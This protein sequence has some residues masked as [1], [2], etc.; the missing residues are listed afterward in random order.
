MTFLWGTLWG[1]PTLAARVGGLCVLLLLIPSATQAQLAEVL[2]ESNVENASVVVDGREVG[3]TDGEGLAFV[4]ALPPGRHTVELRKP[5]YWN[6]SV[7]V[8]LEPGLT[9]PVVLELRSRTGSSVGNLL[10]ETNVAGAVVVLDGEEIGETG[11]TGQMFVSGVEPGTHQ[12]VAR[13]EGYASVSR[14]VTIGET[15]LD[16]TTRLQ[17]AERTGGDPSRP[18]PTDEPEPTITAGVGM[19]DSVRSS[20]PAGG[21]I[22]TR[23]PALIVNAEME[24]ATV[25]VNDSIFGQTGPSGRLRVLVDSGQHEVAVSKEGL[26]PAQ[27][28]TTVQVGVGDERTLTLDLKQMGS[29]R[30]AGTEVMLVLSFLGLS[31][32]VALFVVGIS[33]PGGTFVRWVRERL[34]I[35]RRAR[36]ELARWVRHPFQDRQPFDQYY[37]VRELRTGEFATVYLAHD[38]EMR[39]QVRLRVLDRPYAGKPDHAKSFLDGGRLLKHLRGAVPDAPI[40]TAYRCGRENGAEDGRPFVALEYFQGKTLIAHMGEVGPLAVDDALDVVRQ[41]CVGLR[42]AHENDI[43]HGHLTPANIVIT[44]EDPQ[45]EIKLTGF[46]DLEYKHTTEILTDGYTEGITSYL[47]PDEIEGGKS[48]WQSDMYSVGVLFYKMVTGSP[49]FTHENPVRIVEMHQEAQPPPLPER[50]P[51]TIQPVFY[52][53]LSKDPDQRPTAKNVISVLDLVQATT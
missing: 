19:P 32:I 3:R 51:S 47:S 38:P 14:T 46:G 36:Y 10:V 27:A 28:Q 50:V 31:L 42:A 53:M 21:E 39:S 30:I 49:P 2:V 45:L 4:E 33:K 5:G 25:R 9:T 48:M 16:Q 35:T 44:Q 11:A 1:D 22:R 23:Q 37:V 18:P 24:G 17:L 8:T 34:G 43:S 13:K 15:G 20:F 29:R 6:A 7:R 26:P 41:L 12:V 52:R 40:A